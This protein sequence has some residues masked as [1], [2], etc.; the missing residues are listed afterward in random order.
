MTS[1]WR[2]HR[3][4]GSLLCYAVEI[5]ISWRLLGSNDGKRSVTNDVWTTSWWRYHW[6][7][8]MLCYAV[9]I[10]ISWRLIAITLS[11]RTTSSPNFMKSRW[12]HMMVW[13][14]DDVTI[15]CCQLKMTSLQLLITFT[16]LFLLQ[17]LWSCNRRLIDADNKCIAEGSRRFQQRLW[18]N[19]FW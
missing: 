5:A 16:P 15:Q 18:F 19:V 12:H 17:S 9:E 6:R 1:W 14:H 8:R 13:R 2:H 3:L 11:F 10:A 7:H 4:N